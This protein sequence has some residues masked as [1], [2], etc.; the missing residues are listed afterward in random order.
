M[1][2]VIEKF[3]AGVSKSEL[4]ELM[5]DP[6]KFEDIVEGITKVELLSGI[7]KGVGVIWRETRVMFGKEATEEMSISK[8]ELDNGVIEIEAAS[9]GV[10]YLTTYTFEENE[11]GVDLKMVFAGKPITF[12]AKLMT[13]IG[14]L[15]IGT[16]KKLLLKDLEEIEAY[17]KDR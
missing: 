11:K 5:S 17:L 14:Y 10:K 13:P 15:F 7:G 6:K 9:H 4:M 1:K 12:M 16:T 2:V 3:F 8:Y